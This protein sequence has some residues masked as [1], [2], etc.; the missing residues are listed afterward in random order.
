V[1]VEQIHWGEFL[2][3]FRW[4]QGEHLTI[5]APTGGGKTTLEVAL[6]DQRKYSVFFATKRDDPLYHD[7]IRRHKFHRV[8]NFREVMPWMD[9]VLLWPKHQ[10]T[11]RAT[12]RH[13]QRTFI[14]ALDKIVAQRAW[15][16]WFDEC[17]YMVQQLGMGPEVTFANEQLRSTKGTV[18]NTAQRPVWI[19][20]SALSNASHVFLWK[21]HD[22]ADTKTLS[23]VGGIDAKAVAKESQLLGRHEFIY[24]STRGTDATL[25]RSQVRR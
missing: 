3:R 14:T 11:I 9:R 4:K 6:V 25:V 18:V 23:D 20:K 21:T 24:I 15:S 10:E 8:E 16:V 19:G 12:Y 2:R 22:A 17:K 7:L 1:S 13:Q 5:I